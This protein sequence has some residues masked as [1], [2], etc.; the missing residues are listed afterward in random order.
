MP[1]TKGGL[2]HPDEIKVVHE[3]GVKEALPETLEWWNADKDK[4][5]LSVISVVNTIEADQHSA[6]AQIKL[7]EVLYGDNR[8]GMGRASYLNRW[9][10]A[11]LNNAPK[12][13]INIVQSCID[14]LAS[15]ISSN[16]PKPQFVPNEGD[17]KLYS[18]AK[19]ATDYL[20]GIW[21]AC[22]VYPKAQRMFTDSLIYGISALYVNSKFNKINVEYIMRDEIFVDEI[23]GRNEEPMQL[24]LKRFM[25][26]AKLIKQYPKFKDA[27]KKIPSVK[28]DAHNLVNHSVSDIIVCIESWH[29]PTSD[30]A[31]DGKY[32]MT[33]ENCTLELTDYKHNEYPIVF[34]RPYQKPHDFCGRGLC[35][36]L[37]TLQM[38]LNRTLRTIQLSQDMIGTPKVLLEN[39]SSVNTDDVNDQVGQIIW[40]TGTPPQ[41]ITPPSVNPEIY[42]WA[43][44]VEQKAY[45]I[46]GISQAS[47][48]GEKPK[49]VESAVAME[50]VADIEAGRFENMSISWNDF[51]MNLARVSMFVSE[52]LYTK[53]KKL[54]IKLNRNNLVRQMDWGKLNWDE[55]KFGIQLFP[56]NRLP[57]DPSGRLDAIQRL[58]Q[59]GWIDETHGLRLL[60]MPDLSEETSL[61]ISS[62]NLSDQM[63]ASCL[64]DG[65]YMAP[66]PQMDL[67]LARNQAKLSI[68]KATLQKYPEAHIALVIR[69]DDECKQLQD[70][71][72][73]QAQVE[74]QKAAM[75]AQQTAQAQQPSAAPIGAGAPLAQPMKTPRSAML[76][77]AP[78]QAQ[79]QG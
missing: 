52:D 48:A 16:K 47:A 54:V 46:S 8:Q 69:F 30:D 74:A 68:V 18:K 44:T 31:G 27:L 38:A 10:G 45:Q 60:E 20:E 17:W 12:M 5:H 49:D 36:T 34:F 43:E 2:R 75:Q 1:R 24:H 62:L 3:A 41:Y 67:A 21:D 15:K 63:I 61:M 42:Q 11:A 65:E 26:R 53:H 19:M 40:Y 29:L 78:P 77:N 39:G 58:I 56:I 51:F 35:E 76:P 70:L 32:C 6:T 72:A 57:H 22:Q 64:D 73:Q 7:Y 59:A 14:T 66:I 25:S 37:F 71:M 55:D 4:A 9:Q 79:L 33:V 13:A 23:D 50:S 28:T